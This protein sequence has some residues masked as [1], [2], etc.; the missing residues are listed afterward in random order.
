ML[1]GDYF[2]FNPL[3]IETQRVVFDRAFIIPPN[4]QSSFH[5]VLEET[6]KG[7]VIKAEV[8]QSSFHRVRSA[9]IDILRLRL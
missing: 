5:R 9:H 3:F 1:L 4:F 6:D 7:I 8:F 2:P